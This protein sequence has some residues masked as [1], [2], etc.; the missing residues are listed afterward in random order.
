MLACGRTEQALAPVPVER[1]PAL[2]GVEWC[3]GAPLVPLAE[4]A[5]GGHLLEVVA[6]EGVP[7][8]YTIC[9][10]IDGDCL[11]TCA[12]VYTLQQSESFALTLA[13]LAGC[14]GPACALDCQPFGEA[15]TRSY[16]FVGLVEPPSPTGPNGVTLHVH[17]VCLPEQGR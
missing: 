10:A 1:F 17:R 12:G 2:P 4:L 11:S 15:P 6:V 7:V 13:D 9:T 3:Q 5:S 14:R 16:R 8:V